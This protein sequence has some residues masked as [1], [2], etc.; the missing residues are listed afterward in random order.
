MTKVNEIFTYLKRIKH[1]LSSPIVKP[2]PHV[3]TNNDD[4]E[5]ISVEE[6]EKMLSSNMVDSDYICVIT[7]NQEDR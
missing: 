7:H 3:K 2:H 6:I 4:E 5:Y 1:S